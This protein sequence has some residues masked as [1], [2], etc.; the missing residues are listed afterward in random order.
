MES[1][2]LVRFNFDKYRSNEHRPDDEF[3]LVPKST[4]QCQEIIDTEIEKWFNEENLK[5][6][7][8]KVTFLCDRYTRE[9]VYNLTQ[10]QYY[11]NR[12]VS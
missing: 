4:L 8:D 2:K 7:K 5:S 6:L 10:H 11:R 3:W 9:A 12:Y 1:G